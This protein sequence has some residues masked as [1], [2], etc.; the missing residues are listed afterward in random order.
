MEIIFDLDMFK[1]AMTDI[2]VDLS[3]MPLGA[4][5]VSQLDK[6]YGVLKE[7][8]AYLQKKSLNSRE[9][10][11]LVSLSGNFYQVIPHSYPRHTR[12]PPIDTVDMLTEKLT[13]INTLKDIE[14][15]QSVMGHVSSGPVVENPVD[16]K[17]H[18][19]DSDIQ[20]LDPTSRDYALIT[21]FMN[22]TMGSR[23]VHLYNI[24]TVRRNPEDVTF[25]AFEAMDNHHLLWHGTNIAVVAAILK[26]G[27]RIM[28][29]VNGGRVGR[30]IYLAD[31]LEKSV[32][33]V[34][35]ARRPDGSQFGIAFL[36]QAAMG[37]VA[38]ITRSESCFL[39]D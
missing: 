25:P 11:H 38:E 32:S 1:S 5:T 33:Y 9:R 18:Q 16:A 20:L 28:P 36:S 29:A 2:K 8:E 21:T 35:P 34:R 19:L 14:I 13:M 37:R 3:R 7:I 15:A 24:W 17:Y 12:P 4:I 27:L 22:Q 30:G 23:R 10:D 39:S 26:T 6:G 31:K